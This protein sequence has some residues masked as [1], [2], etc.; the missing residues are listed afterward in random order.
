MKKKFFFTFRGIKN[1]SIVIIIL[2]ATVYVM[3]NRVKKVIEITRDRKSKVTGLEFFVKKFKYYDLNNLSYSITDFKNSAV[4]VNYLNTLD[5]EDTINLISSIKILV[6][7]LAKK[8]IIILNIV[9]EEAFLSF[10]IEPE[11]SSKILFLYD[12]NSTYEL[13]EIKKY[14][15]TLIFDYEHRLTG[16][17]EGFQTWHDDSKV[18]YI[19]NLM[20]N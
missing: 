10:N 11:Y 19:N 20:F 6:K 14:P 2:V 7:K 17:V 18:K 5:D 9:K 1:V 16:K 12:K 8:N 15:Y 3:N 4:L 13:L